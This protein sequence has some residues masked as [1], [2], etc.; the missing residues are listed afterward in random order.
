[1]DGLVFPFDVDNTLLDNHHVQRDLTD[2]LTEH[3][4][5]GARDRYWTLFEDLRGTLPQG[6]GPGRRTP[7]GIAPGCRW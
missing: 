7:S 1:M 5:Q 6:T 4:G 3:Y 2:H